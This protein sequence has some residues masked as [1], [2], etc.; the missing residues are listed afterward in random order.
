MSL[1][2]GKQAT[3]IWG[4]NKAPAFSA[5]VQLLQ[6]FELGSHSANQA[7]CV[8]ITHL[9]IPVGYANAFESAMDGKVFCFR[10]PIREVLRNR[11][12]VLKRSTIRNVHVQRPANE[13]VSP[14]SSD[15]CTN[16]RSKAGSPSTL[17]ITSETWSQS[18]VVAGSY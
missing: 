3:S 6:I 4:V 14:L 12:L 7:P 18:F 15:F 8:F 13:S 16:A 9:T 2:L 17:Y 11:V 1:V 10:K 5:N